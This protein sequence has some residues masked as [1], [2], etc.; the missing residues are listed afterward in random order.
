MKGIIKL[1]PITS[2]VEGMKVIWGDGQLNPITIDE[3]AKT[4]VE[5]N[6]YNVIVL[7]KCFLTP[8]SE[9]ELQQM[10]VEYKDNGNKCILAIPP[11]DWEKNLDKI[12]EEVEFVRWDGGRQVIGESDFQPVAWIQEKA[13]N[14][15][16]DT[17]SSENRK[18]LFPFS[19]RATESFLDSNREMLYTEEEV[20]LKLQALR[21]D[22]WK[23]FTNKYLKEWWKDNKKK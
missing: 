16:V 20:Y 23:G 10:V 5:F 19:T 9:S 14:V 13:V 12:G 4:H 2:P 15:S 1:I 3:I 21:D 18:A 11:E 7:K 8:F 17:S 22:L 6:S